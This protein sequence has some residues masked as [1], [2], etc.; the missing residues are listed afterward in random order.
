MTAA[1]AVNESV[2]DP[3]ADVRLSG[4]SWPCFRDFWWGFWCFCWVLGSCW[5]L[6]LWCCRGL[7]VTTTGGRAGGFE[8]GAGSVAPREIALPLSLWV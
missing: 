1:A 7:V 8:V 3:S 2:A 6:R 5:L 4:D